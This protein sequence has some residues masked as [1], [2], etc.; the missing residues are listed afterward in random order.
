MSLFSALIIAVVNDLNQTAVF[1]FVNA[2]LHN[3]QLRIFII[4]ASFKHIDLNAQIVGAQSIAQIQI[5]PI[6]NFAVDVI[7]VRRVFVIAFVVR[8]L[9]YASQKRIPLPFHSLIDAVNNR[10]FA[11]FHKRESVTNQFFGFAQFRVDIVRGALLF[12]HGQIWNKFDVIA[13]NGWYYS[14]YYSEH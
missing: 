2:R 6:Q 12:A 14:Q 7:I 3:G 9:E 13:P 1:V 5:V 8:I 4:Y 10:V 11:R